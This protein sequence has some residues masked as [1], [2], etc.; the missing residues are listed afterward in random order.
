MVASSPEESVPNTA[1]VTPAF[2]WQDIAANNTKESNR[3]L[4]SE[5]FIVFLYLMRSNCQDDGSDASAQVKLS[6]AVPF[7]TDTITR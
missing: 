6:S 1:D 5:V 2:F 4:L 7:K 3:I